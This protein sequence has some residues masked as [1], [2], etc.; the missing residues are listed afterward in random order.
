[1]RRNVVIGAL[2]VA[3][4]GIGGCGGSDSL[5]R[6]Q[7]VT[8]A[9]AVCTRVGKKIEQTPVRGLEDL[10]R[11]LVALERGKA[12][13]IAALEPPASLRASVD[14]YVGAV[15]A[16]AAFYVRALADIRARGKPRPASVEAVEV[17]TRE[18]QL[19][20]D[21]HLRACATAA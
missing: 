7:F 4:L 9:E 3:V 10:A 15:R 6:A 5:T 11:K 20:K 14:E 13:G 2:A 17:Q 19:A 16:R 12:A 8:R 18:R 21:L 1:M